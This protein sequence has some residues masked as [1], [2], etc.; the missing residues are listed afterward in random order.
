MRQKL[1]GNHI[2]PA[3][4]VCQHGRRSADGRAVLC[5]RKGVVPL[6]YHCRK[7]QYDPLKRDPPRRPKRPSHTADEFTLE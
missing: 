4:E 7:F 1:Y 2:D 5:A 6:Y 3:C